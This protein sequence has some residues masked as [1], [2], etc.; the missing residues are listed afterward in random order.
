MAPEPALPHPSLHRP[1]ALIILD[2]V[3]GLHGGHVPAAVL[4]RRQT[5]AQLHPEP[6]AR[7]Q[8]QPAPLGSR[9][10]LLQRQEGNKSPGPICHL[11]L[12][13]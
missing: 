2:S 4:V 3:P 1:E 8:P 12:Q 7:L 6:D 10:L 5:A 11:L 13:C 9:P